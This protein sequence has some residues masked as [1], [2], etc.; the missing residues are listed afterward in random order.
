MKAMQPLLESEDVEDSED[1]EDKKCSHCHR[2]AAT[3]SCSLCKKE[4]WEWGATQSYL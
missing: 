2:R 3:F 4:V 1:L